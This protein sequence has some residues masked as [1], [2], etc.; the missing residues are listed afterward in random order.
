VT[1]VF[2]L[3]LRLFDERADLFQ[4]AHCNRDVDAAN[5]TLNV[6]DGVVPEIVH[7]T[8]WNA[9]SVVGSARVTVAV[10]VCAG[11]VSRVVHVAPSGLSSMITVNDGVVPDAAVIES[12]DCGVD[13]PA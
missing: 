5:W 2:D 9:A 11:Y 1:K 4:P 8:R 12:R 3:P 7:R 6:N 10:V 13:A